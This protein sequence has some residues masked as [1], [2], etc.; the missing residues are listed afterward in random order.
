MKKNYPLL[1]VFLLLGIGTVWYLFSNKT[2][3]SATTLGWD[4]KFA[5]ENIG[6]VSK[7]FIAKRSGETTTLTRSGDH[8]L[9]NGDHKASPNAVENVLEVIQDVTLKFVPPSAALDH[10]VKEMA[11]RGIKVEVYG[12]SGGLLKSFYIG[13]V[14]PDARATYF[15]M[16]NS[17]QPMAVELPQMEGQLRTRF[18]ITGDYWRDRTVFDFKP[19]DIQAVSI[20]YPTQRN[21]SFRLARNNS[22]FDVKPFYPNVPLITGAVISGTVEGFFVSFENR[23]AESFDNEYAYKDSVRTTIP[24]SIVSVT[25]MKGVEKKVAF[26]P[27]YQK[28]SKTGERKGDMVERYFSDINDGE[29]WMLTQQRVFKNVFWDYEAFFE[30]QGINVKD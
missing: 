26:Y 16:E 28:D 22:G 15:I 3:E 12:K 2:N 19:E 6:D 30:D 21:K 8:W 10:I 20:E 18:D 24:F 11:S 7:V 27:Y 9:V 4:R 5:V 29:D 17:E 13:G 23:I 25:D 14:S 1:F